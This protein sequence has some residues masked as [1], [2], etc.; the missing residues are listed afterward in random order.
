MPACK[1]QRFRTLYIT[2]PGIP[3]RRTCKHPV[4][5]SDVFIHVPADTHLRR[6]EE[7][8][9][10]HDLGICHQLPFQRTQRGVL[11]LS[12]EESLV[13]SLDVPILHDHKIPSRD[14][15]VVYLIGLRPPLVGESL[16]LP[17][18]PMLRVMPAPGALLLP[19]K[20]LLQ[21][22]EALR[23]SDRYVELLT[24]RGRY[25]SLDTEIDAD[26]RFVPGVFLS[27]TLRHIARQHQVYARRLLHKLGVGVFSVGGDLIHPG[28]AYRSPYARDM[29]RILVFSPG[30]PFRAET[31]P[32][33]ILILVEL[34]GVV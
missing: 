6:R 2:I 32:V 10:D 4:R 23:F 14:D 21:A 9:D 5:E 12:A 20:L 34:D 18:D 24:L 26:I 17:P 3:A 29:N 31:Y 15:I 33:G 1:K 19:C 7:A 27:F 30:V 16:I 13:P 25:G 11:H 28:H 22:L 8:V